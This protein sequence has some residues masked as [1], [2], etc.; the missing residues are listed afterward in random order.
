MQIRRSAALGEHK[1]SV[2]RQQQEFFRKQEEHAPSKS[3]ALRNASSLGKL[4]SDLRRFEAINA[5]SRVRPSPPSARL[6]GSTLEM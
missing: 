6:Q 1:N 3:D 4:S 5:V 2:R